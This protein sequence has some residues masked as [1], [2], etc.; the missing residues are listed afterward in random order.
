MISQNCDHFQQWFEFF[1]IQK[2][3]SRKTKTTTIKKGG[4]LIVLTVKHCIF[5]G[6][7]VSG[8]APWF[9]ST[10]SEM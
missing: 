3:E 2:H 10:A 6:R 8:A 1:S 9:D 4:G 7:L 5:S